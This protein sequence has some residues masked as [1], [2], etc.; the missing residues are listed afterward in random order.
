M[1]VE[2]LEKDKISGKRN[3]RLV[4]VGSRR[5]PTACRFVSRSKGGG[6]FG[7][8]CFTNLKC[9]KYTFCSLPL[10]LVRR[11]FEAVMPP[12]SL[13]VWMTGSSAL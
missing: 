12:S 3:R 1:V 4:V 9:L 10:T 7:T 11:S 13:P 8:Y 6:M 2:G 5:L